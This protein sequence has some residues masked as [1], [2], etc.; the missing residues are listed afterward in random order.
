LQYLSAIVWW[1]P[2][3]PQYFS[4]KPPSRHPTNYTSPTQASLD[5]SPHLYCVPGELAPFRDVL[6]TLGVRETFA[7]PQVRARARVRA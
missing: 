2:V 1:Q 3:I 5:L 7:P 4:L 6:A